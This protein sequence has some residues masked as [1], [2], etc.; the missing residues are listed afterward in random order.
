[1]NGSCLSRFRFELMY[2]AFVPTE[3]TLRKSNLFHWY[4]VERVSILCFL[5]F[6]LSSSSFA[7]SFVL[8]SVNSIRT[9]SAE[10]IAI[11][12]IKLLNGMFERSV[13]YKRN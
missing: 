6:A 9:S 4:F 2:V 10:R 12:I 5:S 3:K 8:N 1:M 7:P 13:F 11:K